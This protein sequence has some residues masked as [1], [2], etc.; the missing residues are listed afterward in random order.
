MQNGVLPGFSLLEKEAT[1]RCR[2]QEQEERPGLSSA[3]SPVPASVP[4]HAASP[5]MLKSQLLFTRM[6]EPARS[7]ALKIQGT[8]VVSGYDSNSATN[9][10]R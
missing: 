5:N 8:G 1:M 3:I 9:G 10:Q 6:T 2:L 4:Q 7:R